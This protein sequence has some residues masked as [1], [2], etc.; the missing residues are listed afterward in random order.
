MY[1][2]PVSFPAYFPGEE[3]HIYYGNAE[4]KAGAY[5]EN[6][7]PIHDGIVQGS[8][9]NTLNTSLDISQDLGF[10]TKRFKRKGFS[11]L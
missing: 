6:P 2:N 11:E 8:N 1:A 4:I 9:F 7:L 3:D 10:V 5:G